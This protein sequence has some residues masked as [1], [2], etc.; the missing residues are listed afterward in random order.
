[1]QNLTIDPEFQNL[2][3]KLTTDEYNLLEESILADGCRDALVVWNGIII[4]G[5][6]RYD[7]CTKHDLPYQTTPII[8]DSKDEAKIWIIR[9]QFGRRNLSMFQ[10]SELGLE[11]KPLIEAKAKENQTLS[12]GRGIKGSENS[13]NLIEPIDTR[14]EIAKIAGVSDNTIARV[15]K[16]MEQSSPEIIQSIRDG[17]LTINKAYNYLKREE[18]KEQAKTIEQPK[19]KYRII[20]ADPPWQY[21]D[22]GSYTGAEDHYKTMSIEELCNLPIK[23]IT[24]ENAVLFLWVTSPLLAECFAVIEAWGFKYKSS[25]IWDKVRGFVGH[26]NNV[27]HELLLVCT[28][29]SCMPDITKKFDSI[30][31]ISKSETHSEK[32]E[33][34]RQIIDELYT[35]G[36]RIELF[37]RKKTDG[38]EV[39]GNEIG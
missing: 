30:Q 39:W 24:Q 35:Y 10:R 16:I 7:I 11:L 9:N 15:E 26:Y 18:I 28:K 17:N 21:A 37:A 1:M 20:Y 5:H 13:P 14:K 8:F 29:G 4:D 38:W 34:F 31:S 25:Y 6:N 36:N 12:Q 2:I 33:Q 23:D 27:K 22:K 32:P 19:G 3:P